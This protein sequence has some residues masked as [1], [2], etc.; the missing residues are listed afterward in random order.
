MI[1]FALLTTLHGCC[2]AIGHRVGVA[3]THQRFLAALQY[4]AIL[5]PSVCRTVESTRTGGSRFA[6]S[7]QWVVTSSADPVRRKSLRVHSH[8]KLHSTSATGRLIMYTAECAGKYLRDGAVVQFESLWALVG[9]SAFSGVPR[10]KHRCT[11]L[12]RCRRSHERSL[13]S[14]YREQLPPSRGD[15]AVMCC[16][17]HPVQLLRRTPSCVL[18]TT[19]QVA[20]KGKQPPKRRI[21]FLR[22]ILPVL[23]RPA[24]NLCSAQPK[25]ATACC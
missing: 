22:S 11:W 18:S 20:D 23:E 4:V 10:G 21:Q 19:H 5:N 3:C 24:H 7:W 17:S 9:P 12:A 15:V 1:S 8:A 14:S 2:S 16:S 25:L 13:R 6:S